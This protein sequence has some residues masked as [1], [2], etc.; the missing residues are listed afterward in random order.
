VT[1]RR[2]LLAAPAALAATAMAGKARAQGADSLVLMGQQGWLFPLWD[3]LSRVDELTQRQVL[4]THAEAVAIL[5][6]AGIE[7]AYCLIPIKARIYRRF[8]PAG[9]RIAPAVERR[10]GAV[11]AALRGTGAVAPD[12]AEPLAAA[13]AND[14]HWPV[15][16]KGDTH[17]TPVGAEI[18]AVTLATQ[19]RAQLRLPPPPQPGVR[20]GSIRMLR[21]AIGDLVQYVPAEQRGAFGPEESPIRNVLAGGGPA[22]L[23]EEDASDVQVVGTSNVQPRFNFVPVLSNQLGRAVG[24]S[25]K[26]NN[27]GP[28]AALLDYVQG[29]EFRARR[30]RAI[31]WNH[32]EN[33]MSTSINNPNW[34]QSNLTADSFLAAL[35]QAV[36]R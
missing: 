15:F 5:K 26:P 34:R 11:I 4:T 28:Y 20:L 19:M 16:F 22:A 27:I 2:A 13:S 30:P 36:A 12:L 3:S 21:L 32:L 9:Q 8:L 35:R 10:Y 24:L 6:A 18:A 33:D 7:V 14:P 29:S 31:V 23:L 1:P 17:W 25:W